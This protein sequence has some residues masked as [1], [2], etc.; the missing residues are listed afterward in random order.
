MSERIHLACASCGNVFQKL[1]TELARA[2][3]HN[4]VPVLYCSRVCSGAGRRAKTLAARLGQTSKICA[5]CN[6][7]LPI[8]LFSMKS[9]KTGLRQ[10]SCKECSIKSLRSRRGADPEKTR[11]QLRASYAKHRDKRVEEMREAYR[12]KA[13]QINQKRRAQRIEHRDFLN[14]RNKAWRIANPDLVRAIGAEKRAQR[15]MRT[16][17]WDR[18]LTAL[19]TQEASRLAIRRERLTGVPWHIDH[20]I[21][22]QGDIVSGL[23]VWNNLSVVPAAF[24][25]AKG[26]KFESPWMER[27]WL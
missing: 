23:H 21:P 1:A 15:R 9:S 2:E 5:T 26:N 22:L 10:T 24:N 11:A 25:L 14:S 7:D 12:L 27:G 8:D 4:G 3:R 17:G 18:E 16:A 20:E 13:D 6:C 19:V